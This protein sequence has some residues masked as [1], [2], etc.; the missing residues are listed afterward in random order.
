MLR[1]LKKSLVFCL[2]SGICLTPTLTEASTNPLIYYDGQP[3]MT[4]ASIIMQQDHILI[5]LRDYFEAV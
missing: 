4:Q 3:L 5:S 1:L 2:I